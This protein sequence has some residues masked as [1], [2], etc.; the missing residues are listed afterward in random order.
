MRIKNK[1]NDF[2]VMASSSDVLIV[3]FFLSGTV[4]K[5]EAGYESWQLVFHSESQPGVFRR[6]GD[7]ENR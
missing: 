2:L 5:F 3:Q 4:V 7:H 6:R 1:L